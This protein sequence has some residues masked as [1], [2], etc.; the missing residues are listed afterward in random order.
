[1]M[2]IIGSSIGGLM[3]IATI[4]ALLLHRIRK[5][6]SGSYMVPWDSAKTA[7]VLSYVGM[8]IAKIMYAK[9]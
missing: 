3:I 5:S 6:D 4:L 8:Y 7:G 1:M 9:A 2:T